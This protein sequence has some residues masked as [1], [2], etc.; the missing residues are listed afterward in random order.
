MDLSFNDYFD[1][2]NEQAINSHYYINNIKSESPDKINKTK[3]MEIFY[4][5]NIMHIDIKIKIESAKDM[6][7]A[8]KIMNAY[9]DK[10]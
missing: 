10:E 5:D 4:K 2:L 8:I 6:Q 3:N 1:C 9:L 7:K